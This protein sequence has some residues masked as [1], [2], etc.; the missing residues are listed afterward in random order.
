MAAPR[1]WRLCCRPDI[2]AP[3]I[4]PDA[5]RWPPGG[6]TMATTSSPMIPTIGW[7]PRSP[8]RPNPPN[9]MANWATIAIKLMAIAMVATMLIINVSRFPTWAKL[10]GDDGAQ[11]VRGQYPPN[12]RSDC[13]CGI[14]WDSS[15]WRMRWVNRSRL[16]T[17][18]VLGCWPDAPAGRQWREGLGPFPE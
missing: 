12:S 1:S 16:R 14:G 10:V 2:P 7:P 13:Y 3:W 6:S 15:P 5:R 11:F 8:P 9:S 18:W 4:W 17:P